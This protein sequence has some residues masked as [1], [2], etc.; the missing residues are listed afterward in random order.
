MLGWEILNI[1]IKFYKFMQYVKFIIINL[2][3][4]IFKTNFK[5]TSIHLIYLE[6]SN[7]FTQVLIKKKKRVKKGSKYL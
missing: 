7:K 2:I 4:F 5:N 3:N 6:K 1:G